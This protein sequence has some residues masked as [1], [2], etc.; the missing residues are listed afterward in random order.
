MYEIEM[1]LPSDEFK[2]A[3]QAAGRHLEIQAQGALKSWLK[4][5]L[6]P[7][8]LEH[9]SFRLGNQLFFV[10]IEDVDARMEVPGS[11]AGLDQVSDGCNGVAC[12]LPMRS[13]NGEWIPDLPGWGLINPATGRAIEPVALITDDDIEMTDW[14]LQ[15]FAV[16]I[17]RDGLLKEGKKIMSWHSNPHVDPSI[18]FAGAD[19]AEW[20]I[21]R[22]TRYPAEEA[23]APDNWREIEQACRQQS[24]LGNFASVGIASADDA[25]DP[26]GE[27]PAAT[28]LRGHG[29]VVRFKGTRRL[30][31]T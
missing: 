17:V 28:L 10:R 22:A 9:L 7:P 27:I 20:V 4:A 8:F 29:M 25:F 2:S 26:S 19:G 21:V 14:E 12:I 18:W 30:R 31:A 1:Q 11:R 13:A 6:H 23:P 5:N 3:W 15:D 24:E 16:Q